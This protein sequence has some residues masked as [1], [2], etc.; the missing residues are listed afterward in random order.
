MPNLKWEHFYTKCLSLNDKPIKLDHNE[1]HSREN[2]CM[3]KSFH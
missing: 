3:T 1:R 2:T